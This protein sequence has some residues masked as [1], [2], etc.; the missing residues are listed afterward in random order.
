MKKVGYCFIFPFMFFLIS[1]EKEPKETENRVLTVTETSKADDVPITVTHTM[2]FVY[3]NNK[4][5]SFSNVQ[6]YGNERVSNLT[7][8][9][10]D[11]PQLTVTASDES[12]NRYTYRTGPQAN[13]CEITNTETDNSR[14]FVFYYNADG[15]LTRMDERINDKASQTVTL[16]YDNGSLVST[17]TNL[18]NLNPVVTTTRYFKTGIQTNPDK[19]PFLPLTEEYPFYFHIVPFYAGLMGKPLD[20]FPE[21]S[22]YEGNPD[23]TTY[24]IYQT[25]AEGHLSSLLVNT[26]SFGIS[27]KRTFDY[28]YE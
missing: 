5:T 3:R 15:Y 12:G 20:Y 13:T 19:L 28:S 24:Y 26:I 21:S 1:C 14:L 16:E 25:N 7:T 22:Y 9:T 27:Y 6:T 10:Y 18:Y 4:L 2:Q 17:K 11:D 23:E 8:V